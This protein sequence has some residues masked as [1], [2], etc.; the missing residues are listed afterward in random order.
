[1]KA[2][3]KGS[4]QT[5][6]VWPEPADPRWDLVHRVAGSDTFSKSAKLPAFLRYVCEMTLTDREDEINEQHIGVHVFGRPP[7]Y[8]SNEDSIVR[9][10]ARLLRAKLEAYFQSEGKEEP[11]RI[12]IPKGSYVPRFESA[13]SK[14]EPVQPNVA[15]TRKRP[16]AVLLTILL[17]VATAVTVLA[18][19]PGHFQSPLTHLF[20]TQVFDSAHTTL[21]VPCDTGLVMLEGES[22]YTGRSSFLSK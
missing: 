19:H 21:I 7:G 14:S 13:A 16:Y 2:P 22:P 11:T 20:W 17:A 3:H 9:S 1:M 15:A 8:N 18:I 4:A 10:Q 12:L 5:T 6:A